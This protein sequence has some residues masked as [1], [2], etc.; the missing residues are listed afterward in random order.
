MAEHI[1]LI[2]LAY[3]EKLPKYVPTPFDF[4]PKTFSKT[5]WLELLPVLT[6]SATCFGKKC[7]LFWQDLYLLCEEL[8]LVSSRT[9]ILRKYHDWSLS[10]H[11]LKTL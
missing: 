5:V 11:K 8:L 10:T 9:V 7:Y 1:W 2:W 3:L 6:R 4:T